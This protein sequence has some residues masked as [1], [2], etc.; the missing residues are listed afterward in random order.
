M[1]I[2]QQLGGRKVTVGTDESGE[3]GQVCLVRE[4]KV[5][6]ENQRLLYA[7]AQ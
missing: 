5:I 6:N 1:M 3:M 7:G 4:D 2:S